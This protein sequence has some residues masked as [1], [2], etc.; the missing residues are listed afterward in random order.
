MINKMVSMGYN[1]NGIIH[2][3]WYLQDQKYFFYSTVAHLLHMSF[4]YIWGL[5]FCNTIETLMLPVYMFT[6]IQEQ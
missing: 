2:K 1:K 6:G 5:T 4:L 3:M